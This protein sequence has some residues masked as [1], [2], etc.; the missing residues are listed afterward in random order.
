MIGSTLTVEEAAK[1]LKRR[2]R[3]IRKW[4]AAGHIRANKIGRSY[5]IPE[6]EVEKLVT[7]RVEPADEVREYDPDR[8]SRLRRLQEAVKGFSIEKFENYQRDALATM[9]E[10]MRGNPA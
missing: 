10:S 4:I 9:E 6:A 3:T 8:K 1:Y 7:P 5:V 2:P